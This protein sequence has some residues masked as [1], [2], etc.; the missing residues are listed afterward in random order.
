MSKTRK[1]F[2]FVVLPLLV[3][4]AVAVAVA[5]RLTSTDSGSEAVSDPT[6]D[7]WEQRIANALQPKDCTVIP[8]SKLDSSYYQGSLIDT[9]FHISTIPDATP[10]TNEDWRKEKFYTSPG[11][12]YTMSDYAC[13][14]SQDGTSGKVF[15][16]FPVYPNIEW[17]SL[18]LVKQT[19]Q[20]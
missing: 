13:L 10:G 14:L 12:N 8:K 5:T 9:H 1:V 17:Q 19:I 20:K 18:K 3:I 6:A 16:F 4:F 11:I 7:S 2:L 15:A